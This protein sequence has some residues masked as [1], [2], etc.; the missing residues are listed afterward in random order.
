MEDK[1][2]CAV[3]PGFKTDQ[4][5]PPEQVIDNGAPVERIALLGADLPG[6][7]PKFTCAEGDRISRGQPLFCDRAHPEI[8]FVAPLSGLVDSITLGPRRSLSALV[9][10]VEPEPD[11]PAP[12]RV[13]ASTAAELRTML[14]AQGL[15][16]S[17]L[18]RP[19]GR[20]PAPDVTPDAIFVT[21]TAE[22]PHAPDPRVVL[23]GRHE[24]FRAGLKAL[25]LLTAGPVYACQNSGTD[26][27]AGLGERIRGS[28]FPAGHASGLAG[29]HI[30]RLHPVGARTMVWSIGYQDVVAIG[31]LIE[32][33]IADFSRVVSLSGPR[34]RHPRLIRTSI[35]AN[36]QDLI[37]DDILPGRDGSAVS[38]VSGSALTGRP[39]AWLGRYHQQ[40][41]LLDDRAAQKPEP[42]T[43]WLA[44]L[45][46]PSSRPGPIV[47]TSALETMLGFDTPAVPFLRAL[48]V[49]D[50]ETASRLGCLE[51]LEEDLAAVSLVC[52]SGADYGRMLRHVL[53]ELAEDA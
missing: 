21:A 27:A 11:A 7:R 26:I 33:G 49:G 37:S 48:S 12:Q 3:L 35:G 5:A 25:A 19:F 44:K 9:I 6:L 46:K 22:G 20:T 8:N 16:P 29:S 39:A 42:G 53:D 50:A 10:R 28:F 34:A 17:F 15:W 40:V 52:T 24:Q 23:E 30:H 18:T 1:V 14:L 4:S 47:P 51:M 43:G 41:T 13:A 32:T 38:V 45:R 2:V 31:S 36:L